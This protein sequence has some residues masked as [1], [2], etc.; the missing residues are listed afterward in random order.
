MMH[1]QIAF[2]KY[3][4]K[5]ITTLKILSP[6]K[7]QNVTHLENYFFRTATK[8]PIIPYSH[9]VYRQLKKLPKKRKK[10][11]FGNFLRKST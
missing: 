3:L 8:T 11:P 1:L 5:Q 6:T 4:A 2:K 10:C 7:N 9:W